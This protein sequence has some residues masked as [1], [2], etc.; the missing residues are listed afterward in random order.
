MGGTANVTLTFAFSAS[1]TCSSRT[2]IAQT[3]TTLTSGANQT[4]GSFSPSSNVNVP[5]GSTFCFTVLVNSL[6]LALTLDYDAGGSPTNLVS[7]Q[8]IFI[9]ELVLPFIGVAVLA[10]IGAR[11]LFRLQR[12][13]AA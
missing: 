7:T 10:P 8:M 4:T 11:R 9:P 5:A 1:G 2:T 13:S 3:T 12:R 6:G